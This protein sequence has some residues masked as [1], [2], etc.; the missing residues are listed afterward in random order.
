[1]KNCILKIFINHTFKNYTIIANTLNVYF[2]II[3]GNFDF[4]YSVLLLTKK[5]VLLCD[6]L[7]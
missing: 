4:F 2:I 1:M 6:W 7:Y 3:M 5:V